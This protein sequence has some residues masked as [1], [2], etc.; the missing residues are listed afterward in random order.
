MRVLGFLWIWSR[1]RWK[2]GLFCL[3]LVDCRYNKL[4]DAANNVPNPMYTYFTEKLKDTVRED[5]LDS[6]PQAYDQMSV[7]NAC[8]LLM[9]DRSALETYAA[10]VWCGVILI[11]GKL[12]Y[13]Q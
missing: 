5:I 13:Q 6:L 3:V 8:K 2:E 11:I 7:E 9:L 10:E 4:R 1:R 12:A